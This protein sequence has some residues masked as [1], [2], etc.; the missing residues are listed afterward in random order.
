[1]RW[2]SCQAM[3]LAA[4]TGRTS[5]SASDRSSRYMFSDLEWNADRDLITSRIL[6]CGD[7]DAVAW[8]RK[9]LTNREIADWIS[10][11]NGAG[12]SPK[13]LRFWEL[14]AGLP[15]DRVNQWLKEKH[16]KIW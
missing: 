9:R 11:H 3:W 14:I 4:G 7:W 16:R 1:M 6:T 5:R 2:P 12:L 8:L 13:Q 10:G 15:H